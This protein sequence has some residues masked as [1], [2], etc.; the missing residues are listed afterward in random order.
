MSQ[1][2]NNTPTPAT[3]PVCP[4]CGAYFTRQYTGAM[5]VSIT[6]HCPE[7]RGEL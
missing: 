6:T 1:H 3:G 2:S 5:D 4:H 7:C